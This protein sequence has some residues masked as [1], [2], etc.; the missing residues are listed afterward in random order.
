MPGC[1]LLLWGGRIISAD[2]ARTVKSRYFNKTAKS[3]AA[4]FCVH[5]SQGRKVVGGGVF[6]ELVSASAD[7]RAE[8]NIA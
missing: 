3:I 8:V 4:V 5:V 6:R 1:V 7:H 2:F